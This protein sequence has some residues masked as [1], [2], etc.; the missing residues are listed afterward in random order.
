MMG[1][2]RVLAIDNVPER[3]ELACG[4]DICETINFDEKDVHERLMDLTGGRGPDSCIDAVGC[5]A[6]AGGTLDGT[7]WPS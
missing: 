3:L 5:E 7:P 6:H 1:A 2:G 4:N